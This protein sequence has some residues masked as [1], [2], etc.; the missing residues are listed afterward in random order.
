ML[1]NWFL[2]KTLLLFEK[3]SYLKMWVAQMPTLLKIKNQ[4]PEL[5]M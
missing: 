3:K 5:K 2:V 4:K 1:L